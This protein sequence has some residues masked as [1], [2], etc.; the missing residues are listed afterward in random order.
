[1]STS[2]RRSAKNF[3]SSSVLIAC[4]YTVSLSVAKLKLSWKTTFGLGWT[5]AAPFVKY[6]DMSRSFAS[7]FA[8]SSSRFFLAVKR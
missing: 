3:S 8:C 7:R 4:F 2:P 1:M 5:L 6:S